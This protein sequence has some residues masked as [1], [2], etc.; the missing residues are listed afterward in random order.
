M[1]NNI[2]SLHEMHAGT[3]HKLHITRHQ[4]MFAYKKYVFNSVLNDSS[5]CSLRMRMGILFHQ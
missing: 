5:S 4:D 2:L 1:S 3:L